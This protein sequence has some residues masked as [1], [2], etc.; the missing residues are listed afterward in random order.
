[1]LEAARADHLLLHPDFCLPNL[2]GLL[3]F[4]PVWVSC[5]RRH[6]RLIIYGRVVINRLAKSIL[7]INCHVLL[8][9]WEVGRLGK[10]FLS[11]ELIAIGR[12]MNPLS[13][14]HFHVVICV[15]FRARH[16]NLNAAS[17]PGAHLA[18]PIAGHGLIKQ[19]LFVSFRRLGL[20]ARCLIGVDLRSIVDS[21]ATRA[22]LI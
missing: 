5:N 17:A 15:V 9:W 8:A 21:L 18:L 13:R 2:R 4:I 6:G 3:A 12:R 11:A 20:L 1:M 14:D 22:T 10:L 7:L 19:G 16:S